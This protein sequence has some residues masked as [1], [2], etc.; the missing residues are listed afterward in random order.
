MQS[1]YRVDIREKKDTKPLE[2]LFPCPL[3][4]L[5]LHVTN[6][7]EWSKLKEAVFSFPLSVPPNP[8]LVIDNLHL[9]FPHY[10]FRCVWKHVM[11]M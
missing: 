5:W 4:C 1:K 8:I 7:N 3:S 10:Y 6:E 11:L 9:L 2:T